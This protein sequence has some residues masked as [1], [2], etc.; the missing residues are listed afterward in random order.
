MLSEIKKNYICKQV[1]CR[2]QINYIFIKKDGEYYNIYNPITIPMAV[3]WK[4]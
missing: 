1:N 4:R 3:I 2:V